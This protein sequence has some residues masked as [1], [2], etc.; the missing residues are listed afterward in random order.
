[1]ENY[2]FCFCYVYFGAVTIAR[3]VLAGE[4]QVSIAGNCA[5]GSVKL[6]LTSNRHHS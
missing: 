4:R 1:M 5:I 6:N 2:E 3:F